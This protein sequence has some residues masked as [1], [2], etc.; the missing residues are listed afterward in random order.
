VRW[1]NNDTTQSVIGY[2]YW[3]FDNNVKQETYASIT[4]RVLTQ[5]NY[6]LDVSGWI[7]NQSNTNPNI[8]YFA[9]A[10]QTEYSGTVSLKLLQWRDTATKTF[11]FW[12]RFYV[13]Y[14]QVSQASYATL[15]MN[16]YGYGQEFKFGEG[17]TLAWGIGRTS[18][19]FDGAKSSYLTGYLNFR[20]HF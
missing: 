7:G 11:D 6:K 16:S 9:P 3:V 14:G 5:Y 8:G 2:R 17:R 13:S 1:K 15:P 4:Q 19:P 20:V 18:F 12:H 10:S